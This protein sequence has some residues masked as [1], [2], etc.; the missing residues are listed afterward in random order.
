[1]TSAVEVLG[2]LVG[3]DNLWAW[4]ADD[5][6]AASVLASVRRLVD[7]YDRWI[8]DDSL[9]SL[10]ERLLGRVDLAPGT[11]LRKAFEQVAQLDPDDLEAT[12]RQVLEERWRH[13]IDLLE[14][15]TGCD[16]EELLVASDEARDA[17]DT[18]VRLAR[19][20]L[21]LFE[22]TPTWLLEQLRGAADQVV[23]TDNSVPPGS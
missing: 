2:D 14:V 17:L 23:A 16:L 6:D 1:M 3:V 7:G 13:A 15:L 4:L 19:A 20:S 22:D 8:V 18:A 12:L 5:A 11:P 21:R 10:W 9:S